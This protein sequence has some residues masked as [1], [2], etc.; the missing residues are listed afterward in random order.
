MK[1]H[2]TVI[3]RLGTARDARRAT[4]QRKPHVKGTGPGLKRTDGA[5][6]RE[7]ALVVIVDAKKP[8]SKL[9]R[10]ERIPSFVKL[11]GRTIRTDV[12]QMSRLHKQAAFCSDGYHQGIVSAF[13]N[14]DGTAYGITCAHCLEGE[15]SDL[16]EI[17]IS[18]YDYAKSA[19]AVVGQ[20]GFRFVSPGSGSIEDYGFSDIGVFQIQDKYASKLVRG[21]RP[22][23][24]RAPSVG[25]RV[26]GVSAHGTIRGT[27][28]LVAVEAYGCYVDALIAV[29]GAGTFRGDSGML[30]TDTDGDGICIHAMGSGEGQTGS[31][32][33]AA[34][35]AHRMSEFLEMEFLRT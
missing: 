11:D 25:M 33:S 24:L 26:S 17:P 3:R 21:A 22:M 20:S 7:P 4:L 19:Y 14:I 2:G 29:D 8:I 27:I 12:I 5:L 16:G 6:T 10:Q 30:W 32:Y 31:R 1:A 9:T 13:A 15:S 28:D 34:M 23:K 35:F 18:V